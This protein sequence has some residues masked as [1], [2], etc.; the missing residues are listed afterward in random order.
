MLSDFSTVCIILAN[1]E[2][3]S[4]PRLL[5]A[6]PEIMIVQDCKF[7]SRIKLKTLKAFSTCP[8][9]EYISTR[10]VPIATSSSKPL[11]TAYE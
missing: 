8:H 2:I 1:K 7:F 3:A 6:S 4:F 5:S 9:L 10:A 11:T